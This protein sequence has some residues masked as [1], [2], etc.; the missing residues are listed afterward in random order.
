MI[1]M[2]YDPTDP[3]VREGVAHA[4]LV[5]LGAAKARHRSFSLFG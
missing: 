2:G 5:L 3:N 1:E 4:K